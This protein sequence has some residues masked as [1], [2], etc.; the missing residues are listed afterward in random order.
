MTSLK[1]MSLEVW[2][3]TSE[4]VLSFLTIKYT[5]L[6]WGLVRLLRSLPRPLA[7]YA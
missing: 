2:N 3:T 5:R 6:A 7:P 1:F 4:V